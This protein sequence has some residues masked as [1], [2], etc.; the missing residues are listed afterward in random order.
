MAVN[1]GIRGNVSED[2]KKKCR[3]VLT[4]FIGPS[5][6][7]GHT[8]GRNLRLTEINVLG[9]EEG[10][11]VCEMEVSEDMC[12]VYGTLHGGCAAYLIDPCSVSSLVSLG[13]VTGRDG[14]GV[15]QSMNVIWHR[16]VLKGT[17]LRIISKTIFTDGRLRSASCEMRDKESNALYISAVHTTQAVSKRPSKL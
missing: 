2:V 12:N 6:S 3:Q 7:Y 5:T 8:I 15:S 16:P 10:E 9:G 4:Y 14:S 13:F 11:T 17:R 1:T